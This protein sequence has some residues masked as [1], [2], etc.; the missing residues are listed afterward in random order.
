MLVRIWLGFRSVAFHARLF[1]LYYKLLPQ[2]SHASINDLKWRSL[3]GFA[4]L[5]TGTLS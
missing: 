4:K 2:L 3:A 5:P 1:G